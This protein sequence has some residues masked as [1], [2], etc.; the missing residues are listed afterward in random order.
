M[1]T[2]IQDKEVIHLDTK[3]WIELA[4]GYY[5]R[6]PG[7][8]KI[9]KLVIEKSES[10]QAIFPIS[11]IHFIETVKNQ[12]PKG[13]KRLAEYV[14]RVS[15]GCAILPAPFIVDLEIEDACLRHLGLNGYDLQN[16]AIRRGLSQVV[17]AKA[18]LE[19]EDTGSSKPL[20]ENTKQELKRYLLGTL[21]T[22][23]ALLFLMEFGLSESQL[24]EMRERSK[25]TT[26]E[27][28]RLRSSESSRIKD[29]DLRR[30]AAMANY[31]STVINP[32]LAMFLVRIHAD[33]HIFANKV[34]IDQKGTIRF[35][36]SI[37]TSYCVVQLTFYRDM[38]RKRKIQPND[39]NDI[40]SLSI[41]IPY[42][43]VVVTERMWQTA[44]I[45]TKL[46][47]LYHT[48]VLKSVR[49][50]GPILESK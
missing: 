33:P 16:F 29:N 47:K 36:Q 18:D 43:D 6:V 41:A 28:E 44:I 5:G 23:E 42:S 31:F 13:R 8:Q 19:I 26:E 27:L 21:E 3:D 11:L 25:I 10:G 20:P 9:A 1:M 35:F 39:L 49:E 15:Q 17:G 7:F 45:Q 50:L 4:R 48:C 22:P 24:K 2:A 12:N 46:D 37:P 32:I 30:R 38:Q 14:M 34:L 40:M